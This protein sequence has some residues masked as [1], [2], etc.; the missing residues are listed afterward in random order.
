MENTMDH[1]INVSIGNLQKTLKD[2]FEITHAKQS[3]CDF[4]ELYTNWIVE[5]YT[6]LM[7]EKP[8]TPEDF[9]ELCDLMWVCIQYAN[10]CGYDIEAG[11]NE[12]VKEYSSKLYDKEGRFCP[13]YRHDGKLLKG[14]NFKKA[15]FKALM[16]DLRG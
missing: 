6:E 16:D 12:L 15:D 8:N 5:E 4:K 7:A 11:M 13:T 3:K 1:R 9:K 10:A 14:D 2:L